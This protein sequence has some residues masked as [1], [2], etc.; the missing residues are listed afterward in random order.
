M[1][2][3]FAK[4]DPDAKAPVRKHVTDAGIDVFAREGHYIEGHAI[5]RVRTGITFELN[6]DFM[7]LAMPKSG[8]DF[9]L[10]AGV[11][12]PGYQGEI[13]VKV[14][15][16]HDY[17]IEIKQGDAVAQLIQVPIYI[18]RLVEL[19]LEIIHQVKTERGADGGIVRQGL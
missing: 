16:P 1:I 2:L 9:T 18:A 13:I 8:S 19:P 17:A 3:R 15:N 5:A 12:D 14:V 7:L 6:H 10:G 4:L 11:I